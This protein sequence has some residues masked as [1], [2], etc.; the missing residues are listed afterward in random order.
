VT[1]REATIITAYTGHRVGGANASDV[2]A[3][4]EEATGERV[5]TGEL[6]NGAP[7]LSREVGREELRAAAAG[8][9]A[10]LGRAGC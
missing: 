4:F 2:W 6:H 8:D 5:L 7:V 10:R 3:Y 9:Y 1:L